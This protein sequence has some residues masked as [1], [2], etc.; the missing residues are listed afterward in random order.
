MSSVEGM[1]ISLLQAV[2]PQLTL[3]THVKARVLPLTRMV[4]HDLCCL[5]HL[6]PESVPS[7]LLGYNQ[8]PLPL[9]NVICIHTPSA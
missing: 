6:L 4:L 3:F 8:L 2:I 1:I 5:S 9:I 7:C